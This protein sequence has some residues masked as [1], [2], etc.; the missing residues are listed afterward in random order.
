MNEKIKTHHLNKKAI[1]YIRQSS[2]NQV[3][4]NRESTMRQ[5]NLKARALDLGWHKKDIL[6]IED[7]GLSGTTS[8]ERSGYQKVLELLINNELGMIMSIEM[9]RLSRDQMEWQKIFRLCC[10][11]DTLLAD[12]SHIYDVNDANDRVLLGILGTIS[13]FEMS[14]LK[15]RMSDS[16][17]A[18]AARG[19]LICR[20]TPGYIVVEGKMFKDP[21]QRVQDFYVF[22]FNEYAKSHSVHHLVETLVKQDMEAPISS[23]SIL[24][25]DVTWRRPSYHNILRVLQDPTYSGTYAMGRTKTEKTVDDNGE[26]HKKRKRVTNVN[27]WRHVIHD[28]HEAYITWETFLKN[29]DKIKGN[30][31]K[32]NNTPPVSRG[33]GLLAG[34]LSCGHCG[35]KMHTSY[36]SPTRVRYSCHKGASQRAREK[37]CFSFTATALEEELSKWILEVVSPL[38]LESAQNLAVE[39]KNEQDSIKRIHLNKLEDLEYLASKQAKRYECCDPENRLVATQV[40]KNWNEAMLNVEAQKQFIEDFENKC[41]ATR[42]NSEEL[43]QLSQTLPQI[44]K[45]P[46]SSFEK[47]KRIVRILVDGGVV[48]IDKKK[49]QLTAKI[50]W[51]GG[52]H[53][54]CTLPWKK[55]NSKKKKATADLTEIIKDLNEVMSD[56]KLIQVLNLAKITDYNAQNWTVKS[57]E[58]FREKHSIPEYIEGKK[59]LVFQSEAAELLGV[60]AM[61]IS[62]MIRQGTLEAKQAYPG[63]PW[64]IF[65]EDLAGKRL[66]KGILGK[67]T[68]PELPLYPDSK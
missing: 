18:K 27:E 51:K 37:G 1:I 63:L 22:L 50:R 57:M 62:K 10:N 2:I 56:K 60:S 28:H 46:S 14:M 23:G 40:E 41:S 35:Y 30:V 31:R 29:N 5:R 25:S 48:S 61:T 44:W 38:A 13:D 67:E 66:Q 20:P 65:R 8:R 43:M 26:V 45:H 34:L 54:E 21:N 36:P 58:D 17:E 6:I 4:N 15:K 33:A 47:K 64:L 9:S 19:E 11:Y 16:W 49:E 39:E 55:R 24:R 3:R 59:N 52:A 12:E 42:Y 68:D 32:S 53:S 7:L